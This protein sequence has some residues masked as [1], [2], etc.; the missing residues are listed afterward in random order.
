MRTVLDSLHDLELD[1]CVYDGHDL[2]AEVNELVAGYGGRVAQGSRRYVVRFAKPVAHA[3]TEEL[4]AVVAEL[5][6]G[7]DV[8][9][10]RRIDSSRLRMALGLDLEQFEN[11]HAFALVTA[12]EVLIAYCVEEPTIQENGG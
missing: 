9:F 7:E 4:P 1:R 12:H 6:Q 11:I 2:L 8:G 5:L 3:I 10:L